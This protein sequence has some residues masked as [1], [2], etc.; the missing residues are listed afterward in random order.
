MEG[1]NLKDLKAKLLDERQML[2]QRLKEEQDRLEIERLRN[3]DRAD[4]AM[5]YDQAQRSSAMHAR[6]EKQIEEIDEALQRIEDG[7]Y[8]TCT[9]CGKEINPARLEAIPWAGL[10]V[11]CQQKQ[12]R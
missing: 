2:E 3:P 10:C 9:R 6:T 8:G 4:L 7:T 12:E 1:V 11:E 5:V